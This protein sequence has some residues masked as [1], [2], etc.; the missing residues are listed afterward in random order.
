MLKIP[1]EI[2]TVYKVLKK[3]IMNELIAIDAYK[4]KHIAEMLH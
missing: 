4:T 1:V 3:I 2:I